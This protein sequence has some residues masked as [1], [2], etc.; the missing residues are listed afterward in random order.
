MFATELR[1][2]DGLYLLAPNSTLWNTRIINHSREPE[3]R[4]EIT[5]AVG[6]E[7]DINAVKQILLEIIAA[8]PRVQ[9]NPQPRIAI[10]DIAGDKVTVKAE[11]WTE[12]AQWTETRFHVVERI[13][14]R[15]T[16]KGITTK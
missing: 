3:R 2:T 12:T 15:L 7:A 11:Y 1:N 4:Q 5:V 8:D 14:T 10:D 6:N 9:K 13:K 16:D